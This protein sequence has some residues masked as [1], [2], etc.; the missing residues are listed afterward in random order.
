MQ[1]YT[2]HTASQVQLT[3][4]SICIISHLYNTQKQILVLVIAISQRYRIYS[5]KTM[6]YEHT[7]NS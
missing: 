5:S 1:N 4:S 7:N 6:K 2:K 3:I